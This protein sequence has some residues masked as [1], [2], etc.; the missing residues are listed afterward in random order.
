M[1]IVSYTEVVE[2]ITQILEMV[3]NGE[4]VIIINI[5]TQETVAAIIPYRKYRGEK[6]SR[7]R[8]KR[9]LG[10]LKGKASFRILKDFKLNDEDFFKT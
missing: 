6:K 7:K 4:E 5:E 2:Q 10:I 9:T 8:K 1:K 3:Q